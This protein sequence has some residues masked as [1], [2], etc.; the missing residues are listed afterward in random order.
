MENFFLKLGEIM[1]TIYGWVLAL[2][3][4]IVDYVA[5]YGVMVNIAVFAIFMDAVWGIASARKQ[6]KFALS[7]LMRNTFSK[8]AVYGCCIIFFIGI[9]HLIGSNDGIS[10]SVICV[11]IVLVE[12][13]S[14]IASMIICYPRMPFLVLLKKALYGEIG[15]KLGVDPKDVENALEEIGNERH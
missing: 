7:E 12:L 13:W 1:S 11:G 14:T 10:T 5:G 3:M 6:G 2:V 9:D 15:R 4:L 8:L